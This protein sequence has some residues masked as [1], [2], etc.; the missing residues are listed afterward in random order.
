MRFLFTRR[1]SSR[2]RMA[3]LPYFVYSISS[4]S[5]IE[6]ADLKRYFLPVV[7]LLLQ[8]TQLYGHPLELT[9]KP[10]SYRSE[11]NA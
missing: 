1:L 8:K 4:S 6:I 7:I 10:R 11:V 5:A 3:R 2:K 9:T